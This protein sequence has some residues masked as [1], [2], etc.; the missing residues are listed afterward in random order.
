M[1]QSVIPMRGP[2]GL[3]EFQSDTE[4]AARAAAQFLKHIAEEPD[5]T[6]FLALSGGRAAVPLFQEIARQA[7]NERTGLSQVHFFWVDER[8]VPAT[9]EQSNFLL[10]DR[11]LFK[12]FRIQNDKIHRIQG[13]LEPAEAA[14]AAAMELL[15]IAPKN[16]DGVPTLDWVFLGMGEDGHIGSLFPHLSER[17]MASMPLYQHVTASKPPPNRVALNRAA[18]VQA[19]HAWVFI[20]GPGKDNAFADSISPQ[21]TTPLARL[22]QRRKQTVIWRAKPT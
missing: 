5:R 15:S 13:E 22:L 4:M 18:L 20:T 11:H 9:D 16:G 14:R 6:R 8:C 19:R 12:P 3:F 21:G 17:T 7:Q 10:A 1:A 2:F